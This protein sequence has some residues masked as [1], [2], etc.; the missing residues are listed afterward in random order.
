MA[1]R[2]V[3]RDEAAPPRLPAPGTRVIVFDGTSRADGIILA[4]NEDTTATILIDGSPASGCRTLYGVAPRRDGSGT[5]WE[6][7]HA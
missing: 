2:T 4:L 6:E 7:A 3:L 1:P 5:G